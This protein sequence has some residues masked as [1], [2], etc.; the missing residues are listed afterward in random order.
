MLVHQVSAIFMPSRRRGGG[1]RGSRP[2]GF[3]SI[4]RLASWGSQWTHAASR[5]S[6]LQIVG[7][8]GAQNNLQPVRIVVGRGCLA[9][10]DLAQLYGLGSTDSSA[11]EQVPYATSWPS[12][13]GSKPIGCN[14]F[15]KVG[16]GLLWFVRFEIP[17]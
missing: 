16:I 9:S 8:N 7:G 1:S 13:F 11:A 5:D 12:G 10:R 2:R 6:V 3:R 17:Q 4:H 15:D 14:Q